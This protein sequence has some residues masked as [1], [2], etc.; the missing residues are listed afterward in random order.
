MGEVMA[1]RGASDLWVDA[2]DGDPDWERIFDGY[3][4]AA[5]YPACTF[6]RELAD[7]YSDAKIVL[8]VRDPHKCFESTRKTIFSVETLDFLVGTPYRQFF[9]KAVW[10]DF[11]DRIHDRDFMIS[12][13][14]EYRS[15]VQRTIP[16]GRLLIYE[17]K[18]AWEPLC[19]FLEIP[20]PESRSI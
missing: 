16:Q 5:D 11:G 20:V 13:F 2:A 3:G 19:Q 6:W 9:E 1:S 4:A 8:S 7:C 12:H 15:E 10:R 14:T 18:Q 17:V